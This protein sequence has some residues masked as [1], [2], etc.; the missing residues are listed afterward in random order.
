[1]LDEIC[2]LCRYER[3]YAIKVLGGARPIAGAGCKKRGG[4]KP[5]YG[6]EER[7]VFQVIWMTAEQPCGK[8][9]KPA[10]KVWL[11]HYEKRHCKLGAPD[12]QRGDNRPVVGSQPFPVWKE[13]LCHA[14]GQ[15][16]ALAD[17]G[18][19]RALGYGRTWVYGSRYGCPITGAASLSSM[20]TYLGRPE[21][22][23]KN[24]PARSRAAR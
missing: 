2:S 17:S 14:T 20:S 11:P 18:A 7:K 12:R 10:V 22:G 23:E 13:S 24:A 21:D 5:K 1:M 8:R 16:A 15:F 9:M 6:K 19:H 4:S 3:K